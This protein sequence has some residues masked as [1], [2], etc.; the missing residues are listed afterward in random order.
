MVDQYVEN[1]K[2]NFLIKNYVNILYCMICTTLIR[3]NYI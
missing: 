3:E 2:L 1:M